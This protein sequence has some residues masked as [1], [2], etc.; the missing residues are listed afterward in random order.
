MIADV[1]YNHAGGNFDDQSIHF[2]DRPASTDNKDSLYFLPDGHAGGLIFAFWKHEVRQF[3]ID[4]AK[5]F[6]REYH[7]DGFRYDQVTVMDEHGGWFF[8]QDLTSTLKFVKPSAVHIA[9]YWGNERWRGVVN[10][11]DGMGF[12]AG[13]ADGLRDRIRRVIAQA[14]G[15]SNAR[16]QPG[17]AP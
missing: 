3:L 2:L 17:G 5:M 12:D 16:I 6:L 4:N 11:P 9:E 10:A 8:C 1:V 13:Y 7:V 14:A 15:G